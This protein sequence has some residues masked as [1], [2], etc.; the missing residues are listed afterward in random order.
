MAGRI[1]CW[2]RVLQ[3]FLAGA[4]STLVSVVGCGTVSPP[5]S[6]P[7]KSDVHWVPVSG[8]TDGDLLSDTEE[9]SLGHS[10]LVPD[11]NANLVPD[12]ADLA[13]SVAEW[14]ADLPEGPVQG[15]PDHVY[16]VSHA[17]R[18]IT[19]C[20]VC[21]ETVNMGYVEVVDPTAGECTIVPHISLHYML[22]G[23][24]AAQPDPLYPER[25]DAVWLSA[26]RAS[27]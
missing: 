19:I 24:F 27:Q 25:V 22:H 21:G 16:K 15:R 12:G 3:G 8:D 1:R 4:I 7:Q 9:V 23:S 17:M 11:E 10:P 14:I 2:T 5:H 26:L 6:V 13:T 18:G 20:D